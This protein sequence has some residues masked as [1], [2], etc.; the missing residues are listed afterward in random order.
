MTDAVAETASAAV[1]ERPWWLK[2]WQFPLVAMVVALA[3]VI[4]AAMLASYLNHQLQASLP[5]W[6]ALPLGV[7]LLIALCLLV[8]KLA[9]RRLGRKRH[10]DLPLTGMVRDLSLGWLG[11]AVLIS[12]CVGLAALAGAYRITGPGGTGDLLSIVFLFGIY[13]GFFEE[14]LMRGIVLRWLEEW[15]GS[16]I[17][18]VLSS[19][20]FGFLHASNDNA[21]VFS[22][23]AIALEAGTLL[24]AAYMLTRSLWLAMGLHAGWN[25]VQALWGVAVSGND[26]QGLVSARLEGPELLAGGGFGLEATLFALVVATGAGVWLLVLATRRGRIVPPFWQRKGAAI[27]A[28]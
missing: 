3:L 12:L 22:S 23:V 7:A 14:L 19:L 24:G 11:G 17:A 25:M 21:T 28:Y 2:V 16:W 26:V 8:D 18:L 10:D 9:I 20:L 4:G 1:A 6:L 5:E 15:L 13:A 27:T